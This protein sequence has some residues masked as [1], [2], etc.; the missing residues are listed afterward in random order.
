MM[1]ACRPGFDQALLSGYVDGEL[2]QADG[3]SVR[4]H[5]EDC[6]VCRSLLEE[7]QEIRQVTTTTPFPAPRDEEW[8]ESPRTRASGTLRRLGWFLVIV[9]MLA[10]GG[11]AIE[12]FATS[13]ESGLEKLLVLILIGGPL[14]LFMSVLLDR[15]KALKTDRYRG[16]EK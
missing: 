13:T 16:V 6:S 9:W 5:L 15:L 8:R 1:Q 7:L 3:Q 12:S 10:A 2:T 14:L 11:L 4:L